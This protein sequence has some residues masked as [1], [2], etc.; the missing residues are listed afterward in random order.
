MPSL[1]VRLTVGELSCVIRLRSFRARAAR[2]AMGAG[3]S[4]RAG[5]GELALVQTVVLEGDPD[6]HAPD[7]HEWREAAA[8]LARRGWR[9]RRFAGAERRGAA[10]AAAAVRAAA[11]G[12]APGIV[13]A[14]RG[15]TLAAAAGAVPVGARGARA[16]PTASRA[17]QTYP[18]ALRAHAFAGRRIREGALGEVLAEARAGRVLFVK[19]R[20]TEK[21]FTGVVVG[22][23]QGDACAADALA[24]L[25][26]ATPVWV[27]DAV[28]FA[29]E[30][31]V[32]VADGVARACVCYEGDETTHPADAGA[33]AAMVAALSAAAGENVAGYSLDVGVVERSAGGE[34]SERATVLVEC[35]DGLALGLYPGCP[36]EVYIDVLVARWRELAYI[37][38]ERAHH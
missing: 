34:D 5:V 23:E 36:A 13:V 8:E 21:L 7:V 18:F 24:R 19:P 15:E 12:E 29:A 27:S 3:Q 32:Y 9:V 30:Y 6:P 26:P 2:H 20:E 33:I 11:R 22:G 35:N 25:D 10:A 14:A 37:Q 17:L 28:R 38:R 16:R 1:A 31:R 4:A